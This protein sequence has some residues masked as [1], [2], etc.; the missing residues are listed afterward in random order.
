MI[1]VGIN[2]A[3]YSTRT[4][5]LPFLNASNA[6]KVAGI[7]DKRDTPRFL[8]LPHF[9]SFDEMLCDET[10]ELIIINTPNHC[11]FEDAK[12]ALNAGK[13]VVIEKPFANCVKECEILIKLAQ[14]KNKLLSVYHNSR[15]DSD[16]ATLKSLVDAS[17]NPDNLVP[18]I[19]KIVY[20]EATWQRLRSSLNAKKHKETPDNAGSGLLF[21]LSPHMIDQC[22]QL[23]GLPKAVFADIGITRSNSLVDDY[24]D[25]NLFYAHGLRANLKSSLLISNTASRFILSGQ[26]GSFIKTKNALQEQQLNDQIS[27]LAPEFGRES[28]QDYG[29]L[30]YFKTGDTQL[31][32]QRYPTIHAT[33]MTFY[34]KLSAAINNNQAAPVTAQ[35]S[36]NVIKVIEAALLSHKLGK[37]IEIDF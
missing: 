21:D 5:H 29:L 10:I 12:K 11:H 1:T 22:L 8:E 15:Y 27:P 32:E 26:N 13:H 30:S 14:Q 6:F 34:E 17:I 4:F 3:G 7:V 24:Y 36:M 25:I 18:N 37:V 2:S 35:D 16:F 33:Y 9:K 23:F 20:F 31:Q 28:I 19:G